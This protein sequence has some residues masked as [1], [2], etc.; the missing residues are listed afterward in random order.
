MIHQVSVLHLW[1]VSGMVKTPRRC[2]ASS[3][4]PWGPLLLC[5][6]C[7]V[8]ECVC[9]WE[10][11]AQ[12]A[13]QT[14]YVWLPLPHT[15]NKD[16]RSLTH[17]WVLFDYVICRWACD[18][19]VQEWGWENGIR[20]SK[21]LEDFRHQQQVQVMVAFSQDPCCLVD[22][23]YSPL[24]ERADVCFHW[25][26]VRLCVY[27]SDSRW[28]YYCT[29]P[30]LHPGQMRAQP[31]IRCLLTTTFVEPSKLFSSA[32]TLFS[33]PVKLL[34]RF[35]GFAPATLSNFWSQPGSLTRS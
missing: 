28:L 15:S 26:P 34:L 29:L 31:W 27:V 35:A 9:W 1:T 20:H 17:F 24:E 7:L 8:H 5:F 30:A 22:I 3:H 25:R 4:S 21:R 2:S 19:L 10:G 16:S 12:W 14:R 11:A 18:F 23:S 6:P 13:L 33:R 32:S